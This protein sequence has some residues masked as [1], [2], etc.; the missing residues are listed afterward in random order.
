MMGRGR[1]FSQIP[2]EPTIQRD[3]LN[4]TARRAASLLD[5]DITALLSSSHR[6]AKQRGEEHDA[7]PRLA[8]NLAAPAKYLGQR[9][10]T[11]AIDSC[12][13]DPSHAPN[14]PSGNGRGQGKGQRLAG[15][16]IECAAWAAQQRA[17]RRMLPGIP[18]SLTRRR[19][20]PMAVDP[21]SDQRS[22]EG[23][24]R[25]PLTERPRASRSVP[26]AAPGPI[27]EGGPS[28]PTC[29]GRDE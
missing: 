27:W 22:R 24:G 16:E 9:T 28:A 7:V 15:G 13:G 21:R 4:T 29:P 6:D 1:S 20:A 14:P 3:R 2:R 23:K 19:E 18:G 5:P 11:H 25:Q 10:H 26:T 17:G 8:P 12:V